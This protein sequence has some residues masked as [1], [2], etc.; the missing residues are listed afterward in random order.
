MLEHIQFEERD[1]IGIIT[2]NRPKALN[3]LNSALLNEL[4]AVISDLV[5]SGLAALVLTGSGDRAFAAGADI[6]EMASFSAQEAEAF[7]A[8]G[9][10]V[11]E[12]LETFPAPTI[13][14]VKGFA[15]GGGCEVAMATDM[16]LAAPTAVFGQPE[17][18]LGVIPGFGGT[19]RL[20]RR[21]GRQRAL[22]LMLTGR[23]VDAHE[24]ARLGLVL[25]VVEEGDVLDAALKLAG[26]IARNGPSAVRWVK[27]VVHEMEGRD[28][29]AGLAF[30]RAHFALCFSTDDQSEGMAAF[31]EKRRAAFSGT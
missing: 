25:E 31:L 10:A 23:N 27:Q 13:A 30:E 29:N 12:L 22:E 19:Q 24:A 28:A 2:L 14:A 7:S 9:Q 17:V 21:V 20:I 16:I 3:A 18:K 6:A 11:L 1:G 5:D 15:L 4:A 26:R 8:G